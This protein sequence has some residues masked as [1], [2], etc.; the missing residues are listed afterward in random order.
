MKTRQCT[1]SNPQCCLGNTTL[2]E[3]CVGEC[4]KIMLCQCVPDGYFEHI[5][6]YFDKH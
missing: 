4:G 3:M 2:L 6:V 5:D 1:N